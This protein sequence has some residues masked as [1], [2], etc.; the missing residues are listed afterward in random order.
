MASLYGTHFLGTPNFEFSKTQRSRGIFYLNFELRECGITSKAQPPTPTNRR[1]LATITIGSLQWNLVY[2]HVVVNHLR[3][4]P[5]GAI[6]ADAH[7]Q[8]VAIFKWIFN[9]YSR[10]KN[11]YLGHSLTPNLNGFLGG[12]PSNKNKYEH[13]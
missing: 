13:H 4:Y 6:V 5:E 7:H 8:V 2:M 3:A 11:Y 9:L 1:I 10:L 12:W